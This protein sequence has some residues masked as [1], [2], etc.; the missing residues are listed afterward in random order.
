MGVNRFWIW[1]HRNVGLSIP[2]DNPKYYDLMIYWWLDRTD[3]LV[4][5]L[6][7]TAKK[8]ENLTIDFLW[9]F[10]LKIFHFSNWVIY[11]SIELDL[12]YK[13]VYMTF[14][15]NPNIELKK[16]KYSVFSTYKIWSIFQ[17]FDQMSRSEIDCQK[18]F[19]F[20]L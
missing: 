2:Y 4:T 17:Y 19:Y 9:F 11:Q 6:E 15:F 20:I 14:L 1:P 3:G 13:T 5:S 18:K 16:F 10:F 7:H 12:L 8:C